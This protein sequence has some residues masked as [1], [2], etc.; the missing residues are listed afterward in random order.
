MRNS[1]KL[2]MAVCICGA[3]INTA[4]QACSIP[5]FRYALENWIPAPY[6]AVVFHSG[7]MTDENRAQLD[8][9]KQTLKNSSCNLQLRTV[10]LKEPHDQAL[11][12]LWKL[13]TKAELPWLVLRYPLRFEE[14]QQIWA[15]RFNA[16]TVKS[17][18]DSPKR[19]EI[20]RHIGAGDS[21]VWILLESGNREKDDAAAKVLTASLKESA[22]PITDQHAAERQ[23]DPNA[24]LPVKLAFSMLRLARN[25]PAE[26]L[27]VAIL[28]KIEPELDKQ[29]TPLA[30]PVIGRGQFV[31]PLKSNG[32][33]EATIQ[34]AQEFFCGPCSCQIKESNLGRSLLLMADWDKIIAGEFQ[35]KD[36]ST[37]P[38]TTPNAVARQNSMTPALISS[39]STSKP[40][41]FLPIFGIILPLAALVLLAILRKKK[42]LGSFGFA[43]GGALAICALLVAA[44]RWNPGEPATSANKTFLV[45]FC[46]AGIK[47]PVEAT[48]KAYEQEYG[49]A[50]HLQ[51]GPSEGLLANIKIA[52]KGDLYLPA[53][54]SYLNKAH[55]QGL[56]DDA[57]PLAL[58]RPVIAV[59]KGNPKKIKTTAD[60]Q[61]A[62]VRVALCS[63]AAAIGKVTRELLQQSGEW[64][65]L[66]RK[67]EQ[68]GSKT[69]EVGT[70]PE[71]AN[72]I[73]IDAMDA[74]IIWD[75]MAQQYPELEMVRVP[76]F[77]KAVQKVAVGVLRCSQQSS[78]AL[79]FARYL[80]AS[81]KGLLEFK[82]YGYEPVSGVPWADTK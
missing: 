41:T 32:L 51:Y 54:E 69:V 48:V 42:A 62:D 9:L 27:L 47:S 61:R 8:E 39:P 21:V 67:L 25:D 26:E 7:A 68:T 20:T 38:T 12:D 29:Q 72:S 31:E 33:T 53:D 2:T 75:S 22:K 63:P 65:A 35:I 71:V 24:G 16:H 19:R 15:A 4:T 37:E 70:V 43:F 40:N 56:A 80:A 11:A 5:V 74:G 28:L 10:D 52:Q 14:P 17:L 64:D 79:H 82:K 45:V 6:E 78:A 50:V 57:I 18:L 58:M 44:L 13:Q 34:A 59:R 60:L 49:V 23:D 66:K 3:M 55:E 76:L 30:F 46:A 77:D 1:M 73:K 81:D 36:V